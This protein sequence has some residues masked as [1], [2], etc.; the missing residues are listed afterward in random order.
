MQSFIVTIC[1]FIELFDLVKGTNSIQ[2]L[3]IGSSPRAKIRIKRGHRLLFLHQLFFQQMFVKLMLDDWAVPMFPV[4]KCTNTSE[5][6]SP[7]RRIFEL[8]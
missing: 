1:M 8:Q 7:C 6:R 2:G 3:F 5:N 4:S